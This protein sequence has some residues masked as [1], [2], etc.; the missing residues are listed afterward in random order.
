MN[1]LTLT[2]NVCYS[3]GWDAGNRSMSAGG[4]TVWN[5][6]DHAVAVNATNYWLAY[7]VDPRRLPEFVWLGLIPATH[8]AIA[9]VAP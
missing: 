4:R 6:D 3:I 2:Q 1:A 7:I 8:P 5:E 9:T